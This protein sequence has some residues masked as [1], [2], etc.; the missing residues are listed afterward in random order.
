MLE[1]HV[2][3]DFNGKDLSRRNIPDPN[4]GAIPALGTV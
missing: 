1:A 2:R 4:K 3:A